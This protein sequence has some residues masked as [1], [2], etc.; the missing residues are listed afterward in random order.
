L[1]AAGAG[2]G[3]GTPAGLFDPAAF[4]AELT[5][6]REFVRFAASRFAE[7]GLAYGHGTA[8][9]RD[10][11][12]FVILEALHLPIDALDA[13]L[14]RELTIAERERLAALIHARIATRKPAA[15]LLNRAYMLGHGFYVDERVIVPRSFIGEILADPALIGPGGA[16]V[17]DPGRVERVLDLGTGSGS[18]AILAALTFPNA[19]VDAVD[20]SRDA[21]DVARRNV[22]EYGLARRVSLIEGDLCAPLAGR[23]YDLIIANPPYVDAAAM[24]ALPPEYRCE[25]AI[26]LAGGAAGIDLVSRIVVGAAAHLA[27]GGGLLCEVGRGRA[28]LEAAFP[29][30]EALWLETAGSSGEVFWADRVALSRL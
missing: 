10:E 15:Y 5:T 27:P 29:L 26:A 7:A 28:A 4:A 19:V 2:R 9:A 3:A 20:L 13:H 23:T 11:A 25:P 1:T 24:A 12:A 18:L 30:L 8:N 16:L 21:L 17:S 6:V 14:D 22:E